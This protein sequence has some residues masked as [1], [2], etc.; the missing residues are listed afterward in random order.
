MQLFKNPCIASHP[1]H[2]TVAWAQNIINQKA[3]NITVKQVKIRSVDIGTTTR[4]RLFVDHN[5]T[6][7]IP[8]RWFVKI[9]PLKWRV[10][11]ITALPRLLQT[12]I[13]FYNGIA[14]LTPTTTPTVLSATNHFAK[15]STLVLNDLTEH[16]AIPGQPNDIISISQA[17]LVIEQLAILHAK[18]WNKTHKN[19]KYQ[20]LSGPIRQLEDHLGTVLAVPLM[21]CGLKKSIHLIPPTLHSSALHYARHRRDA[22]NFL[23]QGTQTIIHHDCH[24]GNLFWI[25]SKPGLLDWQMVRAGE[26]IS[27]ISYFIAT[28]LDPEIRRSNENRLIKHYIK[29]LTANGIKKINFEQMKKRYRAHLVYPFEAMIVT[30][31]IGGM[32]DLDDNLKLIERTAL[33]VIDNDAFATLPI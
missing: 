14:L 2:L 19:K 29:I 25:N 5:G 24:P 26:G 18:F 11:L 1:D 33:A 8:R 15:G 3:S 7:E 30:L 20:W 31:A 13:K 27:D 17:F 21:K 12:E 28:C 22:M 4:V 23:F 9:P 16:D 32:M 10:R 6:N